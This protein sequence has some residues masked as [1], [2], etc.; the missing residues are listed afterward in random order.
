MN[1]KIYVTLSFGTSTTLDSGTDFSFNITSFTNPSSTKE[2]DEIVFEAQDSSGSL[3]N[4]YVSALDVTLQT[5]TASTITVAS[6]SNDNKDASQ[7][8]TFVIK[9]TTVNKIPVN[10]IIIVQY[11]VEVEPFDSTV[12]TVT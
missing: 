10:G 5:N 8:S 3:I 4:D 6:I 7:S 9:F 2:T 11:P 12:A 1:K